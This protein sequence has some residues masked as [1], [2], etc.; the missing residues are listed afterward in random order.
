YEQHHESRHQRLRLCSQSTRYAAL[1]LSGGLLRT[2]RDEQQRR[3]RSNSGRRLR[4]NPQRRWLGTQKYFPRV[5]RQ[6]GGWTGRILLE[7]ARS[8]AG[9]D[10]G[11]RGQRSRLQVTDRFADVVERNGICEIRS[12]DFW[13]HNEADFSAFEFFIK[14]QCA[15]D[16]VSWKIFWQTR[17][18]LESLQE[19]DGRIAL[20]RRQAGSFESDCP[21]RD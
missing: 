6:R 14:L 7:S 21:R 15:H 1:S 19:I 2:L 13:R 4:R 8:L 16:F 18:Q 3:V 20:L 11:A 17:R 10:L 12:P 5:R 9:A